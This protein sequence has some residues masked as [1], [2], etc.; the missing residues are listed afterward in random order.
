MLALASEV[1][2]TVR[3]G[4]PAIRAVLGGC[5]LLLLPH[6][7]ELLFLFPLLLLRLPLVIQLVT[8]RVGRK[9]IFGISLPHLPHL[10]C[11]DALVPIGLH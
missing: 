11:T 2:V 8:L 7:T 9:L 3:P 10:R 6:P 4:V 5:P 1:A